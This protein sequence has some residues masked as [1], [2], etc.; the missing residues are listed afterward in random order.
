MY[1]FLR[2]AKELFLVRNAPPLAP[3]EVSVTRHV[4]WPWDL[5]M[6][7]ELNNGRVLTLYDL[8]RMPM[9]RR[10]G[11]LAL[12]KRERWGFAVAGAMVRYRKRVKLFDRIEM[13]SRVIGWDARFIYIEQS[14][15]KSDGDCASHAIYRVAVTSAAG[16]ILP[17]R[18]MALLGADT[19]SPPL[20]AW[21]RS[22]IEAEAQR[23]WPP[24]QEPAPAPLHLAEEDAA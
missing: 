16:M 6:F 12:L 9:A 24:M 14:M 5:D 19:A 4:C 22:W 7:A 3:G 1:P 2:L 15:W 8:G 10:S 20:P 18:V 11:L 17:E 13:R 21:V 23:P